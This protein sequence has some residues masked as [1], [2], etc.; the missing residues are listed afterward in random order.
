MQKLKVEKIWISDFSYKKEL[1]EIKN[2]KIDFSYNYSLRQNKGNMNRYWVKLNA[3]CIQLECFEM[4]MMVNGIFVLNYESEDEFNS[5][6]I[7]AIKR[8]EPFVRNQFF[9]MTNNPGSSPV[10]IPEINFSS[11]KKNKNN[12]L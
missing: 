2:T 5:L 6:L 3:N 11:Y 1:P 8:L 10:S 4:K 12:N 9:L 7:E